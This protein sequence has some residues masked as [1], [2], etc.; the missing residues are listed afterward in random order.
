[1]SRPL[2]LHIIIRHAKFKFAGCRHPTR[3]GCALGMGPRDPLWSVVVANADG[4]DP[5]ADGMPRGILV[6]FMLMR[7]RP[8][9]E[10]SGGREA[11]TNEGQGVHSYS[12]Y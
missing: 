10:G 7:D 3:Q 2:T 8:V 6:F 11:G 12:Y 9:N 1:M 5:M 4:P